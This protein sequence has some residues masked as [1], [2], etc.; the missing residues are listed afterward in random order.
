MGWEETVL[1]SSH[2]PMTQIII[3]VDEIE[4]AL[5]K[6]RRSEG[7]DGLNS[8]YLLYG[9]TSVIVWLKKIFNTNIDVPP[10]L[11]EGDTVPI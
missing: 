6:L 9:G 3:V 11:K 10:F 7:S 5:L 1:K 4:E 8:E 2:L